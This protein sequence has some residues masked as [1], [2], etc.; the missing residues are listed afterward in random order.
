MSTETPE[1]TSPERASSFSLDVEERSISDAVR[2][3]VFRLRSGDPGALPSVIGLIVLGIIFQQVSSRFISGGH[4]M[5]AARD[6]Y[7]F[8]RPPT[9][10]MFS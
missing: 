2:S 8:E 9:S 1:T 6:E 3:W 4:A 5:N 7:A 10:T